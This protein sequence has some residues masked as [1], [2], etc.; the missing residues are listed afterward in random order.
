MTQRTIDL[1][2]SLPGAGD[3]ASPNY[4]GYLAGST[5]SYML[6][7]RYWL[8]RGDRLRADDAR[9][10]ARMCWRAHRNRPLDGIR[11]WRL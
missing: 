7:A 5:H 1:P 9:V 4:N 8:R 10:W 3:P 11:A 6:S 2:P